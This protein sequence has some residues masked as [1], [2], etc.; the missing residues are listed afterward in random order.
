[1]ISVEKSSSSNS[2]FLRML[3]RTKK[4]EFR[5]VV[6]AK[7]GGKLSDIGRI[8]ITKID[9]PA[10]CVS[11]VDYEA[12]LIQ[13]RFKFGVLYCRAEQ[14]EEQEWYSNTEGSAQFDEF[15]SVLGEKITLQGWDKFAGGLNTKSNYTGRHSIYTSFSDLE[16]MFHV[17][18]LLPF[19]ASDLQQLERKRHLGSNVCLIL[20]RDE[21]STRP[22]DPQLIRSQFTYVFC[23]VQPARDANGNL[24]YRMAFT[25]KPGVPP[26]TPSIPLP[27]VFEF[28]AP[29]VA[30]ASSDRVRVLHDFLLAK[31]INGEMSAMQAPDFKGRNVRTRR[32]F[33]NRIVTQYAKKDK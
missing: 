22:F 32:D 33:L 15:L 27:G 29:T 3:T 25:N 19:S 10:L 24:Q 7:T 12:K 13:R 26:Y 11:L 16:V 23:V 17:S 31:L 2:A 9:D 28:G 5:T 6:P 18:T 30:A 14:V 21:N 20:F 1:V 8:K 4:G